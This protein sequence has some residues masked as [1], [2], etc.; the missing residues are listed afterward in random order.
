MHPVLT[1]M[2]MLLV[3]LRANVSWFVLI[4]YVRSATYPNSWKETF[5]KEVTCWSSYP[6]CHCILWIIW[7]QMSELKWIDVII[8]ESRGMYNGE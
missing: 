1:D 2:F 8:S 3:Y 7:G 4:M 6:V 5:L